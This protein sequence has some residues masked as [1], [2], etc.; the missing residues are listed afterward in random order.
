MYANKTR[1][2]KKIFIH[3][4]TL[5]TPVPGVVA[6]R[7]AWCISLPTHRQRIRRGAASIQNTH[8]HA[9][10]PTHPRTDARTRHTTPDTPQANTPH[11]TT[12]HPLQ[13]CTR[14]PYPHISSPTGPRA[15]HRPRR[16][17][18]SFPRERHF[19]RA[20]HRPKIS[21]LALF[22]YRVNKMAANI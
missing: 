5:Y 12:P 15:D 14:P 3:A 16:V 17:A 2:F 6:L 18:A 19:P 4:H 10:A 1:F 7:L 22:S 20:V 13:G 21:V 8:R 9:H 11:T